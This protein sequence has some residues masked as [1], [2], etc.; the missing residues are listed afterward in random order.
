[1]LSTNFPA[2]PPYALSPTTFRFAALAALAGRAP[3]GG[4]REVALATYLVARLTHDTLPPRELPR[5]LR[6]ERAAA[7]RNWLST[8]ALPAA[9]RPPLLKLVDA[10]AGEAPARSPAASGAAAHALAGVIAVTANYLGVAA[11]LE[12]TQL[13]AAIASQMLAG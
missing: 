11:S 3:I 12:L 9:V 5:E 7:A 6:A 4:K 1:V 2:N 8:L 10:T 13:A